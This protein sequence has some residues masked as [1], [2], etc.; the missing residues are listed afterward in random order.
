MTNAEGQLSQV[1]R[2]AEMEAELRGQIDEMSNSMGAPM[3]ATS[4]GA[5]ASE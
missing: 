4:G 2:L 1:A 3:K 5:S